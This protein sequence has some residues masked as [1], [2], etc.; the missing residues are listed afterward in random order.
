MLAPY[1]ELESAEPI[2]AAL[3]LES[4][5]LWPRLLKKLPKHVFFQRN[6]SLVL[7]HPQD[8]ADLARFRRS[9][10]FKLDSVQ[11]PPEGFVGAENA[12]D[13]L[14]KEQ[15]RQARAASLRCHSAAVLLTPTQASPAG[16]ENA[17]AQ[18]TGAHAAPLR[19]C[20]RN[21]I[22]DLEP[23]I[24]A[25]FNQGIYLPSEGQIDNRQV[26]RALESALDQAGVDWQT[27]VEVVSLVPHKIQYVHIDDDHRLE[28]MITEGNHTTKLV[29]PRGFVGAD[30]IRPPVQ[31]TD[32]QNTGRCNR[33]LQFQSSGIGST[34]RNII[35]KDFDLVIDC[36]GLGGK[37]DL[38]QLRG[39]RGE[40]L[41]VEA[42]GVKLN[43][44]IRLMH[45]RHPIYIVPR[46]HNRFIIGATSIESE[47]G[48]PM[49]V[50]SA[51]ELLSAAC[52]VHP[53]FAEGIIL[54]SR[55]NCPPALPDNL[56]AI[57]L[58]SEE[59]SPIETNGSGVI[60][61]PEQKAGLIRINGL[62]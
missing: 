61:L 60:H 17:G 32:A 20:D 33:P 15:Q 48:R 38:S 18:G 43:R 12:G 1:T 40:L 51:L 14:V 6:G 30:C 3:G 41:V 23:E 36:R 44:P 39:V 54:E 47:D 34:G 28:Q 5:A 25:I 16:P 13:G 11:F 7:A 46:E 21:Q 29:P 24:P 62:Y 42:P 2:I 35:T 19:E 27:G 9:V 50:Q 4:L 37:A 31:E 58:L 26:L 56:P 10:Q 49:T 57:I 53:E 55:V 52:T 8:Q 45:P 59:E 22:L